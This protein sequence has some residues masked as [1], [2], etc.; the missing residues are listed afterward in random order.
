MFNS[1]LEKTI[2]KSQHC[3]RNW[4][5]SRSL[6]EEDIKT[7]QTAVTQCSSKQNR[8]F[9]K[10]HFIT[11]RDIIE[12]IYDKT[13]GF[14]IN[15]ETREAKKNPQ[16]LANLVIAFS[17]DRDEH[18]RTTEERDTQSKDGDPERFKDSNIALGI[19]AG[20]L[21]YT[22]N[23]LGYS[24]G[25]CQCFNPEEVGEVIGSERVMLMMGI[26]FPDKSR[27]RRVDMKDNDFTFP[28]FTK[29]I[30]VEYIS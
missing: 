10:V 26:G 1:F 16:V 24:T 20:Y 18:L 12:S 28:T 9:Y 19:A 29:D 21:T 30:K 6:P 23:L 17:E 5:L 3:Q 8:V 11:N 22:A 13:E 7:L 25:C 27:N 2:A 4:D 15:F 14:M